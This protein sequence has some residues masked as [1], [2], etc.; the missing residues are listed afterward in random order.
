MVSSDRPMYRSAMFVAIENDKGE[1]LLQRRVNTG[2]FDGHYD[3]VSGHLEYDESCEE[4]AIRET[5]EECGVEVSPDDLKLVAT[6][7]SNFEPNVKYLNLIYRTKKFRGQVKIGEPDKID[8]MGWYKPEDFP[9]KLAV[10]AQVFLT[11]LRED[12][13][14]NY[15]IDAEGYKEMMGGEYK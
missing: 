11:A 9:K 14:K 5:K 15:Y 4:C 7:Q 1:Y 10:G 3:L 12:A 6:F 8:E 13:V 2:F